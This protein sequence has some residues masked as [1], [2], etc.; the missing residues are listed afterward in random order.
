MRADDFP[1]HPFWD[2]S[3]ATYGRAG[4]PAACLRLQ[5]RHQI[6]V[7]VLLLCCWLGASGRGV[8]GDDALGRVLAAVDEWHREVVRGLRAVRARLKVAARENTPLAAGLRK[9]VAALEIDAEHVEQLM[10]AAAADRAA[11]AGRPTRRRAADAVVNI[12]AY[13]NALGAP[14]AAADAAAIAAILGAALPDLDP[15]ALVELCAATWSGGA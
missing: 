4:V 14:V 5:E 3:L 15:A 2:F 11:E 9:E 7:N 6:D 8:I 12:A 10:L 13:F 1:T